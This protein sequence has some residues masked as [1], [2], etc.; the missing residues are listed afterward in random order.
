MT[1]PLRERITKYEEEMV[2]LKLKLA[3]ESAKREQLQTELIIA[4]SD[5]TKYHELLLR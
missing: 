1:L 3:E 4:R 2:A 5:C